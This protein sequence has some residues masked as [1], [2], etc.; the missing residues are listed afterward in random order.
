M[1]T[2]LWIDDETLGFRNRK[3]LL[4]KFGHDLLTATAV[5]PAI[6]LF[7]NNPVELVILDCHMSCM[8]SHSVVGLFRRLRPHL[9]IIMLSSFCPVPCSRAAE[10]D[11]CIQKNKSALTLL[12][13]IHTLIRGPVHTSKL[14]AA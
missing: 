6:E 1:A 7:V 8:S 2:I 11:V 3:L 9:P 13:A 10:V 5:G 14:T 12:T 4:K